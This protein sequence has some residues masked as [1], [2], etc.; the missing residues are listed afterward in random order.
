MIARGWRYRETGW[1]VSILSTLVLVAA[2]F[3]VVAS[4]AGCSLTWHQKGK[5]AIAT[6][7]QLTIAGHRAGSVY[8]KRKCG[9]AVAVC[10]AIEDKKCEAY[11]ECKA[12]YFVFTEAAI[13]TLAAA[14]T[15]AQA[16]DVALYAQGESERRKIA[17]EAIRRAM[18]LFSLLSGTY[19]QWVMKAVM[20]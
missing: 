12:D 5:R 6:I 19:S 18:E 14:G 17:D 8:Y 15:A 7:D 13:G 9:D 2:G 20:Q 4:L 3:A 16:I 1:I 11:R 10:K